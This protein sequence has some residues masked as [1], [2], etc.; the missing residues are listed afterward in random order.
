MNF[1][2]YMQAW[3]TNSCHNGQINGFNSIDI[4]IYKL[5]LTCFY[6]Y[7]QEIYLNL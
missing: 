6:L 4:W 7:D 5:L 2:I 1:A 3:F